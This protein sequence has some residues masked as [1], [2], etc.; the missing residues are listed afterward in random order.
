MPQ[1]Y[2]AAACTS[3]AVDTIWQAVTGPG[4]DYSFDTVLAD[5]DGQG[6]ANY[7]HDFV[8]PSS[9]WQAGSFYEEQRAVPVPCD[10][11]PGSYSLLF[12]VYD[13]RN[14]GVALPVQSPISLP[15]DRYFYVTTVQVTLPR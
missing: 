1:G 12:K 15:D 14:A 6:K 2:Q 5:A 11:P 10:V 8:I 9:R 13:D 4:T 3:L 7:N